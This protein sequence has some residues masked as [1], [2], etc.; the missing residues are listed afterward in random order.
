[1][2]TISIV[3]GV[4]ILVLVA[5][6]IKEKSQGDRSFD[7]FIVKLDTAKVTAIAIDLKKSAATVNFTKEQNEWLINNKGKKVQ[8]DNETIKELLNQL[9]ALKPKRV[10]STTKDKWVDY[11]V[12]DTLGTRITLKNGDKTLADLVLG[13]FSYSQPQGGNPYQQQQ[14]VV[15]TSYI[16]KASDKVVYAVDGYLSMMFNRDASA[17]R[18]NS[19]VVGKPENWKKITFDYAADRAFAMENQ[20]GKW[21]INGM[22]ADSVKV[23]EYFSKIQNLTSNS[24]D[25]YSEIQDNQTPDYSVQIEGDN[26]A[27]IVVKAFINNLGEL[28]YTSSQNKGSVYKW[29]PIQQVLFVNKDAFL[30]P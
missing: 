11:E 3:L 7:E 2:K 16:R 14:Q 8:A 21:L 26:L 1:M 24:F 19:V 28:V 13:K 15:M 12:N 6:K 5:I 23:N 10:A 25:D 17:F 30:K 9:N 18:E 27:P 4:L 29:D 20:N 22:M